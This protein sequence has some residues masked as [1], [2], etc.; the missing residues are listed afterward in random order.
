MDIRV[1]PVIGDSHT[2][3]EGH[4]LYADAIAYGLMTLVD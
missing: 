2:R 1:I 4:R 3:G